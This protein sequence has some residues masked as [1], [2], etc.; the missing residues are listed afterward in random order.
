M[1]KLCVW[2]SSCLKAGVGQHAE[3]AP[4]PLHEVAPS[5]VHA[6][7][8]SQEGSSSIYPSSDRVPCL[9]CY[10]HVLKFSTE[11]T[12]CRAGEGHS[13]LKYEHLHSFFSSLD[14][15]K[16]NLSPFLAFE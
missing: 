4:L 11:A 1:A 7:K 5:C 15:L 16:K 10:L 13:L 3:R 14:F 12:K 2:G 9:L 8:P 6:E